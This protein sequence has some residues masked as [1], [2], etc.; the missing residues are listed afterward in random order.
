MNCWAQL[1][2]NYAQQEPTIT[3]NGKNVHH[4]PGHNCL[5]STGVTCL[6]KKSIYPI[7]NDACPHFLNALFEAENVE[8]YC[9]S[10]GKT[11]EL[12][13]TL[14]NLKDKFVLIQ[15]HLVIRKTAEYFVWLTYKTPQ[16][17]CWTSWAIRK[18]PM[19]KNLKI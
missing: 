2:V 4:M 13:A 9:R 8:N 15:T 14:T 11:L 19:D 1:I 12:Q 16:I 3:S 5:F 7:L 6:S 10:L 18:I 17:P